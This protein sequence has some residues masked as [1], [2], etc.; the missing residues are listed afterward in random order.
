MNDPVN[1]FEELPEGLVDDLLSKSKIVSNDL[2]SKFKSIATQ[3]DK[4]RNDLIEK[5]YLKSYSD[6]DSTNKYPT[7]SGVDG[8]YTIERMLS[9][10]FSCAAAVAVEGLVPPGPEKKKWPRPRYFSHISVTPHNEDTSQILRGI[11]AGLELHL[12]V[13]APHDV[14]FLDGSMKTPLI[15]LNNATERIKYVPSSL[16]EIFLNGLESVNEDFIKFPGLLDVLD[17][18]EQILKSEKTNKIYAA[19]PKYTTDNDLAS[20]LGLSGYEDRGLLNFVLKGGE[21]VGPMNTAWDKSLHLVLDHV[22]AYLPIEKSVEDKVER[23]VTDLFPNISTIYYRPSAYFPV[24]RVEVAN[25]V[26]SN[27]NRLKALLEALYIQ[28]GTIAIMEPY[29]LY[30]A[31]RMVKHLSNAIPAIKKSAFQNISEN[32]GGSISDVYMAMHSYRTEGGYR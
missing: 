27:K 8:S 23:F 7:S 20:E 5:K 3:K 29:P 15:F 14:V 18:F 11:S 25:A 28:S 4:I 31:D 30:M 13:N 12:A 16:R 26:I 17:D 9:M 1:P 6:L 21:Y 32:W 24:M 19:V 22:T 10:D 2:L